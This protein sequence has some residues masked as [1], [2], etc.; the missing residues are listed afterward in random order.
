MR[1]GFKMVVKSHGNPCDIKA[2]KKGAT[3]GKTKH[4]K[5]FIELLWFSLQPKSNAK[6]QMI[7]IGF[8]SS[9]HLS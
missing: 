3:N 6:Q 8:P 2:L 1:K 4:M 5:D 7:N 9:L